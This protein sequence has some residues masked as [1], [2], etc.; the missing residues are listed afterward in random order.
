MLV[1]LCDVVL[2]FTASDLTSADDE[3]LLLAE[4]EDCVELVSV[5]DE[6]LLVVVLVLDSSLATLSEV[7]TDLLSDILSDN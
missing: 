1:L 6:L 3:V 7:L 5:E 2:D 4:L